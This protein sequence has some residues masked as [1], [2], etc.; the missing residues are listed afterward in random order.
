MTTP[1]PTHT[2]G[3]WHVSGEFPASYGV[4]ILDDK[5]RKIACV[6]NMSW[7]PEEITSVDEVNA[8]G[9]LIRMAPEML[10]ELKRLRTAL[11]NLRDCTAMLSASASIR[12]TLV[13]RISDIDKILAKVSGEADIF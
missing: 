9:R 5:N 12:T 11:V 3:P 1:K 8:N 10:E 7:R 6:G 4:T 13:Y 2:P